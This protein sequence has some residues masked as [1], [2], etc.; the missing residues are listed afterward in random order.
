M[1][2]GGKIAIGLVIFLI[3]ITFPIWYNIAKGK[4]T[5]VP[6]LAPAVRAVNTPSGKQCIRPTEYMIANHMN[7]LNQW[8]DSVVR[9]GDRFFVAADGQVME[10]SLTHTCLNCHADK[11]EFCDKCHSYMGVDPYCW[12][13][14]VIPKET[15][16]ASR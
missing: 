2:D 10:R 14:H 5:Y 7:I 12:N 4:A 8:R 16:N 11:A 9:M 13:C 1:R 3:L 6:Q 15:V